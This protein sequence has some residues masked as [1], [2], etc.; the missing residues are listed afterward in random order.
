MCLSGVA[1][2][3]TALFSSHSGKGN[4][5]PGLVLTLPGV[6]ANTGFWLRCRKPDLQKPDAILAVQRKLCRAKPLVDGCAT[7]A[8]TVIALAPGT[9]AARYFDVIGSI[10]VAI[11]LTASGAVTLRATAKDAAATRPEEGR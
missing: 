2:P 11:Y 1:M 5:I 10:A 3:L 8:L 6:A 7:V 4:V 9:P